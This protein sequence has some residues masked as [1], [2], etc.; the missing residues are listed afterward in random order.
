MPKEKKGRGTKALSSEEERPLY[1]QQRAQ[2]EAEL[3]RKKEEIL[4]HFLRDKLQEDERNTVVNL[5]KL[6]EGWRSILRQSRST[7]LKNDIEVLKQTFE[8]QLDGQDSVIKHLEDNVVAAEQQSAQVHRSHQMHIEQL[9]NLQKKRMDYLQ[10]QWESTME[11]LMQ[12]YRSEREQ[13]SA[14]TQLQ[15]LNLEDNSFLMQQKYD[16]MMSEIAAV[17]RRSM[18]FYENSFLDKKNKLMKIPEERLKEHQQLLQ[19]HNQKRQ[20][21][22]SLIKENQGYIQAIERTNTQVQNLQKKLHELQVSLTSSQNGQ[23]EI[24]QQLTA[25]NEGINI[26]RTKLEHGRTKARQLLT[27]LTLHS[28]RAAKTLQTIINQGE[29]IL[30]LAKLC[31]KLEN[32][33]MMEE[34]EKT[35]TPENNKPEKQEEEE[36]QSC[37][38]PELRFFAQR[39]STALLQREALR[40]RRDAMR[41]ENM[42]LH[43]KIEQLRQHQDTM[44]VSGHSKPGPNSTAGPGAPRREIPGQGPPGCALTV[45]SIPAPIVTDHLQKRKHHVHH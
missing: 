37:E 8:R 17:Y 10:Q 36:E 26:L 2:A 21:L 7:E 9:L 35:P 4:T 1:L 41:H 6:D 38:F 44:T 27:V 14:E 29:R 39:H 3:A 16:E 40:R 20:E 13:S 12:Q 33:L 28:E 19:E 43:G 23:S 22:E 11:K 5:Q 15:L 32:T 25:S 24:E 31:R 45:T 18:D 30:R 34:L 42:Q